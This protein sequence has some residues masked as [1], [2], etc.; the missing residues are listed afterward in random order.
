MESVSFTIMLKRPNESVMVNPPEEDSTL[1]A[2]RGL[3][4]DIS[5]TL[6]ETLT[7]SWASAVGVSNNNTA[8]MNNPGFTGLIYEDLPIGAA[9][10]MPIFEFFVKPAFL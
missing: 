7:F 10:A 8:K 9:V 1:T 2:S 4:C 3:D 6:P 5:Y